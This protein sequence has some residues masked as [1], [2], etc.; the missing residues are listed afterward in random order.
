MVS[1][2]TNKAT[3]KTR[4]D[5]SPVLSFTLCSLRALCETKVFLE[6][7]TVFPLGGRCDLDLRGIQIQFGILIFEDIVIQ[8]AT[9]TRLSSE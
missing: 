3:E 8:N 5:I 6:V 4:L 1:P 2:K 9:W 7:S